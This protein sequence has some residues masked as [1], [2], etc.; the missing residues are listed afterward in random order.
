MPREPEVFHADPVVRRTWASVA[1]TIAALVIVV[2]LL[3]VPVIL[4][5]SHDTNAADSAVALDNTAA[6]EAGMLLLAMACILLGFIALVLAVIAVVRDRG[7][8]RIGAILL[9]VDA[10]VQVVFALI[11]VSSTTMQG[12][13]DNAYNASWVALSLLVTAVAAIFVLV[14]PRSLRTMA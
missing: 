13:A 5:A 12:R 11:G 8:S 4:R 6:V 2:A 7:T 1:A 3:V 9:L 10:A 14:P